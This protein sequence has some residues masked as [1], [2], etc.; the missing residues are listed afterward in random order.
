MRL[1]PVVLAFTSQTQPKSSLVIS[2]AAESSRTTHGA[3][4]CVDAC[5]FYAALIV[6]CINNL[7]SSKEELLSESSPPSRS[8]TLII[9]SLTLTLI[10]TLPSFLLY[11]LFQVSLSSLRRLE[12]L[13]FVQRFKKSFQGVTKRKNLQKSLV[14]VM[15]LG[16]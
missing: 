5:R 9:H 6:G 7:A 12:T 10:L 14:V 2:M 16:L 1:A 3:T 4:S 15:L 13:T 11:F 8:H